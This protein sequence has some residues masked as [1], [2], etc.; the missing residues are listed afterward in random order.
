MR[1]KEKL[2]RGKA[3]AATVRSI[4]REYGEDALLDYP[5]DFQEGLFNA[6][7]REGKR[8]ARKQGRDRGAA[9]RQRAEKGR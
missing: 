4:D 2:A 5:A 6:G 3:Y 8:Y 1:Q 7:W 9:H